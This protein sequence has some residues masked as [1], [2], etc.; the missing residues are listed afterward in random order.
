MFFPVVIYGCEAWTIKRVEGQ[1]TDAFRW[2]LLKVPWT[3]RRSN[4]PILKEISPE[5]SLEELVLKLKL[6]YFGHLMWRFDSLGKPLMLGKIEGRKRRRGQR[7][8]QLDSITD[9]MNMNLSKL[10]EIV[11]HPPHTSLKENWK[12]VVLSGYIT[13]FFLL[14]KNENFTSVSVSCFYTNYRAWDLK[15]KQIRGFC[16]VIDVSGTY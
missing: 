14:E 7:M 1:R 9:S 13:L 4:Q 2:R 12:P 3:A 8:R 16:I 10:G 5:Y 6:Q 11:R 15:P